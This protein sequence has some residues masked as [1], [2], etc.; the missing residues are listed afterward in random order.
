MRIHLLIA[1]ALAALNS[2]CPSTWGCDPPSE[3][4]TVD[5]ELSEADV[6]ELITNWGFSDRASITCDAACHFAYERER[7]WQVG[8]A[9]S[10]TLS[11]APTAGATPETIVGS[12]QCEGTGYEYFCEG[13][14]PLGH[15]DGEHRGHDLADYLARCAH[16]EAASVV[17]F[18]QIADALA[19][20]DAPAE[21]IARCRRAAADEERH[22]ADVGALARARGAAPAPARQRPCAPTLADL[23]IDNAREG[24]VLEAWAALRAAFVGARAR[25]PAL[26]RAYAPLAADEAEHAELSWDLHTWLIGQVDSDTRAAAAAAMDQALA[27]LPAIARAQ[28][29]HGPA[30]LGLDGDTA[31][32]LARRFAAGLRARARL[33]AHAS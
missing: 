11:V 29:T 33:A 12:V 28:A 5:A 25:D 24:C 6:G 13:R 17:A 10:C 31:E 16:L 19:R 15:I 1:S 14:R 3:H 23:A 22:A 2:G 30:A 27:R 18:H 4:F 32:A 8:N 20:A 26:R 9:D 7:S 21:L